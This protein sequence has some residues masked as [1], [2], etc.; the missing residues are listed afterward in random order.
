MDRLIRLTSHLSLGIISRLLSVMPTL[1]ITTARFPTCV[2]VVSH[3]NVPD[4]GGGP[5]SVTFI[6]F[7]YPCVLQIY[8][9]ILTK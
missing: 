2:L 5:G 7:I 4:L 8:F 1:R 6:Y 3:S 9:S